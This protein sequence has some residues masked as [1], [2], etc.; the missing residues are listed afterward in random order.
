MVVGVAVDLVG[1]RFG[2][3]V[4]RERSE[5][6]TG[7]NRGAWWVCECDCGA[8]V[9]RR[10]DGLRRPNPSCGGPTCKLHGHEKHK[11]PEPGTRFGMLVAAGF[12]HTNKKGGGLYWKFKCDCGK[13]VSRRWFQVKNGHLD[14]C[15]CRSSR[16]SVMKTQSTT[17]AKE[18]PLKVLLKQYRKNA[19]HRQLTFD[20]TDDQFYFLVKQPCFFCGAPPR[21][22]VKMRQR[23][24]VSYA[25]FDYNGVDRWDSDASYTVSNCVP[26]CKTCNYAK[27]AMSGEEFI[28]WMQG[29]VG[30]FSILLAAWRE[31]KKTVEISLRSLHTLENN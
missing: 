8:R 31:N 19:A 27:R 9:V 25:R 16:K 10:A 15:G 23:K 5:K 11:Y 14:H 1:K 13:E 6:R 21:T 17:T 4:V 18:T 22:A 12:S 2:K 3:L 7:G 29:V 20:L 26:C 24:Y 28:S 30:H